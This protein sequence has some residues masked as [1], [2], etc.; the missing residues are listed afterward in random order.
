MSN[1]KKS[2]LLGQPY[3]TA[4]NRLRKMILFDLIT[5]F[6]LDDCYRCGSKIETIDD[7]SMEHKDSWQLATNPKESF[8]DLDNIAF[9]HLDCNSGSYNR[10]KTHCKSGHEFTE[11][12]TRFIL[13]GRSCRECDRKR[14]K[15]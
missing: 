12:N 6:G 7:L 10:E 13:H 14:R 8:F 4:S 2:E 15:K 3:G 5:R 11:Q 1:K 9:S